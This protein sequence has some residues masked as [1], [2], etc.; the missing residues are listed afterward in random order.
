ME[1]F[2]KKLSIETHLD[3]TEASILVSFI[4]DKMETLDTAYK[5]YNE[6]GVKGLEIYANQLSLGVKY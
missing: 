2:I 5:I 3:H 1:E 4:Y 6:Q